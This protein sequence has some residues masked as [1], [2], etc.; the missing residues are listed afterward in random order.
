[1]L[2]AAGEQVLQLLLQVCAQC[3]E[4]DAMTNPNPNPNPNPKPNPK[5]NP[6]PK[7]DAIMRRQLRCLSSW[8][9]NAW[10]PSDQVRVRV[11]VW[12]WVRVRVRVRVRVS[13]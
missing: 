10:L 1:M 12:V 5:P 6:N 8:L 7:Q 9:R 2:K 3:R 4:Q 11:R 13:L